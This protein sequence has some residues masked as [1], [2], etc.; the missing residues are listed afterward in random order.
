LVADRSRGGSCLACHVMGQAGG[1]NLPGNV[2][3]DLSEIGNAGRTDEWFYNYIFDA[4]VYNP[5]TIMPPWGAHG[6]YNDADIRDIV[7]FL[8]TLKTP[9]KYKTAIDDPNKRGT[10]HEDRDN[11]D[12]MVNPA[13]WAIDK[14]KELW[15]AK[16]PKGTACAT[17]HQNAEAKFKTYAASMPKWEPRLKKVLG[18]EEFV[19][20]HAKATT[21]HVWLMQSEQNLAIAVYLRNLANGQEIKVDVASPAAKAAAERGK[22][23]MGRKIGQLNFA[24]YDCHTKEKGALHWIRGQWLGEFRGQI[25][26]FPTWRTSKQEIWDIRKRFQWCGVAI[27]ANELPPEAPQYGEIELYLTSLNNGLKLNV[28]GIRH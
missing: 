24:C 9:I 16:G 2:A 22:E 7:A 26:H 10:P 19:F 25:D 13:M 28:P 18:I 11:L 27:R 23:L 21:G 20:R 15:A 12:P 5:E 4:R 3:P 14:A 1:A 17:C 6:L 8:K